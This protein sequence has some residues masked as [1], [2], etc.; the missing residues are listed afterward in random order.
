VS[1]V[2]E[3]VE[4][5]EELISHPQIG[6]G[7]LSDRFPEIQL[8]RIGSVMREER[9][10]REKTNLR[11]LVDGIVVAGEGVEGTNLHTQTQTDTHT[12][13]YQSKSSRD[14]CH[15]K[16]TRLTSIHLAQSSSVVSP[17]N[18]QMSAPT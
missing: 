4:V 15:V 9:E 17:M 11:F 10:G 1:L 7:G 2:E 16:T 3:G 13:T 12:P 18:P 6:A 8:L 5:G 14:Q